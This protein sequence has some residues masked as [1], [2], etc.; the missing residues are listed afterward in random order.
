VWVHDLNSNQMQVFSKGKA[1]ERMAMVAVCVERC[2][3][4]DCQVWDSEA[5]WCQC[6]QYQEQEL[7]D[8]DPLQFIQ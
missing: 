2:Q 7:K 8:T 1:Y 6:V 4:R 3:E 5:V